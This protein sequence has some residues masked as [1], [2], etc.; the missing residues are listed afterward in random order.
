MATLFQGAR[1]V[2]SA[3]SAACIENQGYNDHSFGIGTATAPTAAGV[4]AHLIKALGQW[5]SDAYL[6]Y[7][8]TPGHTLTDIS[9][10]IA[11]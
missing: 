7:I 10:L 11:N 5:S 1:G 9:Q 2:K 4:S 3:L 8:H 6:L